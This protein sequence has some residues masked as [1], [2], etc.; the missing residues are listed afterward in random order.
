M[1][2]AP[3]SGI[4]F[5]L[6]IGAG[7]SAQTSLNYTLN[8][9]INSYTTDTALVIERIAYH[10]IHTPLFVQYSYKE[11]IFFRL[12]GY[13]SFMT[14]AF[15]HRRYG[16]ADSK[17]R[18]INPI[19]QK[20]EYTNLRDEFNPI[21]AGLLMSVGMQFASGFNLELRYTQGFI[22]ILK[23]KEAYNSTFTF[24]L[25]YIINYSE[26]ATQFFSKAAQHVLYA[27]GGGAGVGGSINYE[28]IFAQHEHIRFS[29][30]IGLGLAPFETSNITA[31]S[32]PIGLIG[33]IGKRNH[34]LELGWVHTSIFDQTGA[35]MIGV[36]STG[37]RF[38]RP[39]GGLFVRVAYTPY[40]ANYNFKRYGHWG[41]V[42][43]GYA[44]MTKKSTPS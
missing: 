22:P 3:T 10:F 8:G 23:K 41:G 6:N 27:E 25:N 18:L 39:Q 36:L 1:F 15:L 5:N 2:F 31:V 37:Y 24:K 13:T 32:L 40:I 34:H 11:F 44:F 35:S 28:Y 38:Q 17:G 4:F 43:V 12:G 20:I 30:R 33:M 29:G 19:T 14:N 42:S 7:F 21:D 26:K 9:G 16:S